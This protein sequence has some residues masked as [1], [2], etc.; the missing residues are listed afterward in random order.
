[1]IKV[2]NGNF[3]RW[4]SLT[5]ILVMLISSCVPK[6][7]I[8]QTGDET[9][10]E[11]EATVP[12]SIMEEEVPAEDVPP[13]LTETAIP[14]TPIEET[15]E[16]TLEPTTEPTT[17]PTQEIPTEEIPT[18][19]IP[20]ETPVTPE[21]PTPEA[22]PTLLPTETIIPEITPTLEAMSAQSWTLEIDLPISSG[23]I[24]AMGGID[25]AQ[26]SLEG[27]LNDQLSSLGVNYV[28][29]AL[30]EETDQAKLQVTIQGSGGIEEFRQVAYESLDPQYSLIGG[31]A[32]IYINGEVQSG[33][34]IPLVIESN[35]STGYFWNVALAD[36]N[37]I[38]V[39][40]QDEY[41]EE[42]PMLGAPMKQV[43]HLNAR[44]N[45]NT[46]VKLE[47]QRPWDEETPTSRAMIQ[48]ASLSDAVD[49]S[50]PSVSDGDGEPQAEMLAAES[51]SDS[52][53]I[54]VEPPPLK[55]TGE[56]TVS[57]A[58]AGEETIGLPESFD[59]RTYNKV[60]AVRNQGGCGSCWAFAT[61]GAMEAAM[62]VQSNSDAQNL[63]EQFL[64][65]CN[66]SG[67]DCDGG[68]WAHDYHTS[69]L[70]TSQSEIGAVLEAALPYT[71]TNGSC[72]VAFGHPY[73]LVQWNYVLNSYPTYIPTADAIKNA[74]YNYGPVAVAVTVGSAF[75]SYNGGI[76]TT[77]ID[78]AVNHGVVLVGWGTD[79][80][81]GDYWIMRN[82]WGSGWG[83]DGYMRI[84]VGV[85]RIGYKAS[86]VIY[87]PPTP[88]EHDDFNAPRVIPADSGTVTYSDEDD[89][90]SATSAADDPTFPN[91][92]KFYKTVWYQFTPTSNG[93]LSI[94]TTGSA[95]DTVLG[96]WQGSRG[97]LSLVAMNDDSNSTRQSSLSD[98]QLTGGQTY[99]FEVASYDISPNGQLKL[100]VNYTPP[101]YIL[102]G[103]V[104]PT[105]AGAVSANP[106]PNCGTAKYL[107]GTQVTLTA[108]AAQGFAFASWSGDSSGTETT[109]T[110]TMDG[111]KSVT[112]NFLDILPPRVNDVS[113][114]V[115]NVASLLPEGSVTD[116]SVNQMDITFNESVQNT[117]GGSGEHDA[118][119]PANY[120][121]THLGADDAAGGGDDQAITVNSAVYTDGN[122]TTRLALNNGT[123]L[124]LGR[125]LIRVSGTTSIKDLAGNS[126]DGN[127]DGMG[128][129]DFSRTFIVSVPPG[130]PTLINPLPNAKAANG[131]P[132]FEWNQS[133]DAASYQ[134]QIDNTADFASP[135]YEATYPVEQTSF[136]LP[137][138]YTLE[139]GK[140]YW[141]VRAF[142]RYEQS[143]A[144]SS[145][146]YFI[147]DSQAPL[148]PVPY[149][150]ASNATVRGIPTYTWRASS[151]SVSYQFRF[152]NVEDVNFNA[153]VYTS[154]ESAATKHKP[155]EQAWGA[156][157]W[158]VRAR[159]AAGNWSAWSNPYQVQVNPP[160]PGKVALL[161]PAKN[162]SSS[163]NSMTLDWNE[164]SN[165]VSYQLQ[166]DDDS[167]F[168]SP[169]IDEIVETSDRLL[170][171][172]DSGKYYWRVRALNA[173]GEYGAWS[174]S[175][176]FFIDRDAPLP[177]ALYRPATNSTTSGVPVFSWR[178]AASARFYQFRITGSE[179][180]NFEAPVHTSETTT[181]L[182][183]K[184]PI[185]ETGTYIWQARAADPAL[186]WSDWSAP[187]TV[188]ITAPLPAR[189][190]ALSPANKSY[191]NVTEINFAWSGVAFAE[192]Y[193]IQVSRTSRF[194]SVEFDATNEQTSAVASFAAEGIYYWRVRAINVDGKFGGWN[195][196]SIFTLD[197]T[198]PSAPVTVSPASASTIRGVPTFIWRSVSGAKY[199]QLR[200][201]TAT[202]SGFAAPL[203]TSNSMTGVKYKPVF[204]DTGDYLWQVRAG[205]LAG[206]WGNWSEPFALTVQAAL[207]QKPVLSTP[208]NRGYTNDSSPAFAWSEVAYG[209]NYQVQVSQNAKF[210]SPAMD[211]MHT[212]GMISA[213]EAEEFPDGRYYWHVRAFN[214]N[215]EAGAWSSGYY[216]TID[217][218]P[219]AAPVMI[220]PYNEQIIL[221]S[222]LYKWKT[223]S[224]MAV[225]QMRY[226]SISDAGFASPLYT[227]PE[228]RVTSHR[229]AAQEP[230]VYLWQVRARDLAGN[231]GDWS[232]ARIVIVSTK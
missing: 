209:E 167:R 45:A 129:D 175:W 69:R 75:S 120:S 140:Y 200:Y 165:A 188:T 148:P 220:S 94:N 62:M 226:T 159:D 81:Y 137:G 59:W 28:V 117:G 100:Q 71:A 166:L 136:T 14:E 47:Y 149:R 67:W 178:S 176:Y 206:N 160:L 162:S 210:I 107:Q 95:Y 83:E 118:S 4:L 101:C 6:Y 1:M 174:I 182:S 202:D 37:V 93:S 58:D 10:V 152:T 142:N 110:V 112:A 102:N 180:V 185:Q 163:I 123:A 133:I 53:D 90:T 80:T 50:S 131:T 88:P 190:L 215:E 122:H 8:P 205:D 218:Q 154:V 66:Q 155:A 164:T 203:F 179:D 217:T 132:F 48:V 60:P 12:P 141:R 193:Q 35:P 11:G 21:E 196:T 111:D 130:R 43:I 49:L 44:N 39:G 150:P 40:N 227:S 86:Y 128:G 173:V 184:P 135:V 170:E 74:I 211:E 34:D 223:G 72:N 27:T 52:A 216:F 189:P 24:V 76:F 19:E 228:I 119:N 230:G 199:Y 97:S 177:P 221:G 151:G 225:Y 232:S 91:L 125:Y 161:S 61:V 54:Y 7:P 139:E 153:P 231:W 156:H 65:S 92:Y 13:G 38:E 22:S 20:T 157:L 212:E 138:E 186:N 15:A 197:Q 214:A 127:S 187:N 172:P 229:P 108:A 207:P 33:E 147:I 56:T 224:G 79:P 87:N 106:A 63:S 99:Y 169:L 5:I 26:S 36:P 84:K 103:V 116:K 70:A 96:I 194:T 204:M 89:I 222:P 181:R 191:H 41:L 78:S 115:N 134:V 9:P 46:V 124:P 114:V 198:A 195:R 105:G 42:T 146:W 73:Q 98:I 113:Q 29:S 23:E 32:E 158:Q 104:S 31:P 109:S 126:L 3:L 208:Y 55:E 77:N 68:W 144:W 30:S 145:I 219:P 18:E 213:G 2:N 64:V 183:Y 25:Q 143:G 121:L 85:S 168:R 17:E 57:A 82:S 192:Q 51:L 201:T 16:P 171:N